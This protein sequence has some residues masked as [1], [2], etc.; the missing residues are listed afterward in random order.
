MNGYLFKNSVTYKYIKVF[1]VYR[2]IRGLQDR[3]F[4]NM[5]KTQFIPYTNTKHIFE[6]GKN[7]FD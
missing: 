6:I 2:G 3:T 4:E 5:Y 1:K 7:K